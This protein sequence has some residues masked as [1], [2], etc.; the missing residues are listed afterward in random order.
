MP[1]V[2]HVALR[3]MAERTN[4]EVALDK[5]VQRHLLVINQLLGAPSRSHLCE[6]NMQSL[7]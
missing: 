1:H 3:K 6:Q 4:T 5:N 2:A 7:K